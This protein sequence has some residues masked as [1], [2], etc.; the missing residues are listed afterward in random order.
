MTR[1]EEFFAR[2]EE[3]AN[4]FDP[5]LVCSQYTPEFMAAGP[6]GVACGRNDQELRNAIVQRH[7]F[8][9]QIGYRRAKILCVDATPLDDAYANS[10]SAAAR[11]RTLAVLIARTL[12]QRRLRIFELA[13]GALLMMI[14]GLTRL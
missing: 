4:S 12:A 14:I 6:D 5:D 11:D 1:I 10:L 3:G 13:D 9:Q 8:F 7:T 2:Y